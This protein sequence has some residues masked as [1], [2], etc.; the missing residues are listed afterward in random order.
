M[1]L[2]S[3]VR[4]SHQPFRFESF[5][6]TYHLKIETFEDLESVLELDEA[7]WVATTA[8]VETINCDPVFLNLMDTDIKDII[9]TIGGKPHYGGAQG[10]DEDHL[11]QFMEQCRTY[12]TW[13]KLAEASEEKGVS[14]ILPLNE[15]KHYEVA[16]PVTSGS[17]GNIRLNKGGIF[18]DLNG[19]EWHAKVVQIVENP[20]SVA[21]AMFHPF[22]RVAQSLMLRLEEFSAKTEDKLGLRSLTKESPKKGSSDKKQKKGTHLLLAC[23]L[24]EALP[25]QR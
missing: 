14:E 3:A 18:N 8:P 1:G 19:Q 11:N 25:L 20:I 12:L 22:V 23:W 5:G 15:E 2:S 10:V 24:E 13:L 6:H 4:L 9:A 7:H 16:V 21:E 17:R